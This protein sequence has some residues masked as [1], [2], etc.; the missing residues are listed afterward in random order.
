MQGRVLKKHAPAEVMLMTWLARAD[1]P[2]GVDAWTRVMV[3]NV[4][5]SDQDWEK[6]YIESR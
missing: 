3:V 6:T 5:Q 1:V 4:K 2:H